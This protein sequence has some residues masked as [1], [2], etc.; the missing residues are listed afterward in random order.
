MLTER[1]RAYT[2][3]V[4]LATMPLLTAYGAVTE[5]T[6]PLFVALAGTVLGFGLAAA[7]TSTDKD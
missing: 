6:A 1:Q 7:N 4:F 3:R 5:Q 2:Y